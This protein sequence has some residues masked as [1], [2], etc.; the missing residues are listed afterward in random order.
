[1]AGASRLQFDPRYQTFFDPDDPQR[2]AFEH[3]REVFTPSDNLAFVVEPGPEGLFAAS[4]L[5]L[6]EFLTTEGWQL[7][8]ATRVESLTNFTHS[9]AH[10]DDITIGP[11]VEDVA[12]LDALELA[13]IEGIARA[14][15]ML[16]GRL[17]EVGGDLTAVV[18]T[19]MPRGDPLQ[20]SREIMTAARDL[21]ARAMMDHPEA[22]IRLAGIVAM[23]HAFAESSEQ[24]SMRLL[25]LMLLLMLIGLRVLLAS[26][27]LV[28][29]TF[30]VMLAAVAGALGAAGWLGMELTTPSALAPIII[31]TV[32]VADCVH[33]G[34]ATVRG[35]DALHLRLRRA[36][37]EHHGP[38]LLT[39]VTTAAGFLSM[40]FSAVPPFRDLGNLV[41]I[42][43]L[44]AG[45][46]SLW[47]LPALAML[48]PDAGRRP[49]WVEAMGRTCA[50]LAAARPGRR[51]LV[52]GLVIL[53]VLPGLARLGVNDDFVSYFAPSQPFR[54]A[55]ELVDARL[56]GM[57]EIEYQLKA[58]AAGG[59]HAPAWLAQVEAF[60]TWLRE[61]P[62]T[63]HVLTYTD[64]L[65][66]LNRTLAGDAPEAY[67]LPESAEAAAQYTLLYELSL[68]LGQDITN[69]VDQDYRSVRLLVSLRD[70]DSRRVLA[71]EQRAGAWLAEHAPLVSERHGGIN[72]M[73][74]H[75]SERNVAAMFEG[76]LF[77]VLV[78]GAM[79]AVALRAPGLAMVSLFTNLLPVALAF[80][81]WGWLVQDL[82][83]AISA[84]FGMTLGIVVDDTVHLLTRYRRLR[85]EMD[86]AAAVRST[87]ATV[88]PALVVTTLIL[89]VGFACLAASS[90]ALNA[91]L[92]QITLLTIGLA[93]LVDLL[94][95]PAWLMYR[96]PASES[97]G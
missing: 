88:G 95:L 26:W 66:R 52:G 53:L 20:S 45:V 28:V 55:A 84:A 49:V 30:A 32:A 72:L 38:V 92:A 46:M 60:A 78:I 33:I 17:I 35:D 79:L 81:V 24:D 40:N 91:L 90:F 73:F 23:N 11:L 63:A 94:L 70:V 65:K 67:V 86:V 3:L 13:R 85:A 71:F 80:A 42:G 27:P 29:A 50:G 48:L 57:Y 87:L 54:E 64:V 77:A 7:P 89:F 93:L 37:D 16:S 14:D 68:P 97:H 82:G 9:E 34:L 25:P 61:Q 43:V 12:T 56:G 2:L 41:A 1:M 58:D 10:G 8:Y 21:A 5:G 62:E 15:P 75:I 39:T 36:L 44:L 47:L 76:N 19:V 69:M 51:L 22:E 74:A 18:V 59:I 83:L 31:V 6:I 4:T 96:A